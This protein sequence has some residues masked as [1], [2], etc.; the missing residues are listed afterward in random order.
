MKNHK[1]LLKLFTIILLNLSLIASYG[2]YC[3]AC[4]TGYVTCG[5]LI[6]NNS[7]E[8][9]GDPT[10]L[11]Y[12]DGNIENSCCWTDLLTHKSNVD[13]LFVSYPDANAINNYCGG[14][15]WDSSPP[16]AVCINEPPPIYAPFGNIQK[17]YAGFYTYTTTTSLPNWDR[18][19]YFFQ[20]LST[21]IGPG[22]TVNISLQVSL[23]DRSTRATNFHVAF[24]DVL[25]YP[26]NPSD[27]HSHICSVPNSQLALINVVANVPQPSNSTWETITAT[28]TNTSTNQVFDKVIIGNFFDNN[29]T[30]L[31]ANS[32]TVTPTNPHPPS[33]GI[34]EECYYGIDDISIEKTQ[35]CCD[36]RIDH[37]FINFDTGPGDPDGDDILMSTIYPLI[38]PS[39]GSQNIYIQGELIIDG[40]YS[41]FKKNITFGYNSRVTVKQGFTLS[42]AGTPGQITHLHGCDRMW[43]G[44]FADEPNSNVV[45]TNTVI[46]DAVIGVYVKNTSNLTAI[47]SKFIN[48]Y[49]GIQYD[50]YTSPNANQIRGCDFQTNF[51]NTLHHYSIPGN[52]GY[53]LPGYSFEG[54]RGQVGILMNYSD[55]SIQPSGNP[56]QNKFKSL[57]NGVQAY[58]SKLR[59][60]N[61][62]FLQMRN[63]DGSGGVLTDGKA[64]HSINTD[65]GTTYSLQVDNFSGVVK[66][67]Q[68]YNGIWVDGTHVTN[69]NNVQIYN[70]TYRGI[71]HNG[72]LPITTATQITVTNNDI[73]NTFEGIFYQ[74]CGI[75][76]SLT[77]NNYVHNNWVIKNSRGIIVEDKSIGITKLCESSATLLPV[78]ITNN[79][80]NRHGTGI[81]SSNVS[82]L[83][84][85]EN[86]INLLTA[87]HQHHGIWLNRSPHNV[88]TNNSINGNV[89]DWHCIG[90]RVYNSN[91]VH[92]GCNNIDRTEIAFFLDN[93]CDFSRFALNN[94][95]RYNKGF[96]L[97]NSAK[98]GSQ[99]N[100][101]SIDY[102]LQNN[103]DKNPSNQYEFAADPTIVGLN[104]IFFFKPGTGAT[105]DIT[106]I[107]GALLDNSG[108]I[109]LSSNTSVSNFNGGFS[110]SLLNYLRLYDVATATAGLGFNS[111][112]NAPGTSPPPSQ[113]IEG[114]I[115]GYIAN[116]QFSPIYE[117]EHKWMFKHNALRDY[118]TIK[119]SIN[120]S[121]LPPQVILFIDSLYNSNIYE[122]DS[123][124]TLIGFENYSNAYSINSLC[125][126]NCNYSNKLK[127]INHLLIPQW[128]SLAA[129]FQYFISDTTLIQTVIEI[130]NLCIN[131]Y[132]DAVLKARIF[133]RNHID[134]L[135]HIYNPCEELAGLEQRAL[136]SP[137]SDI[138][139]DVLDF[140]LYPNPTSDWITLVANNENMIQWYITDVQ[141]RPI[142]NGNFTTTQNFDMTQW[143]AGMYFMVLFDSVLKENKTIPF[144]I[145]H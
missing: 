96:T 28:F 144:I 6:H 9:T 127:E 98:L 13:H 109:I 107:N 65:G 123:V 48:D 115:N 54:K 132:G 140:N 27:P 36:S 11:S 99:L 35:A 4:E 58:N 116:V 139:S 57:E 135:M 138:V 15:N 3:T 59:F 14:F 97:L 44:V 72:V 100:V 92:V 34:I 90:I 113:I 55:V 43:Q 95:T 73:R 66:T 126:A 24:V 86:E 74:Y 143:K 83:N 60:S 105:T 22:E 103:F 91:D 33:D 85:D 32:Y 67:N 52:I 71:T 7:F 111:C 79:V 46:E 8:S 93:D 101:S 1:F 112:G 2:Q 64:V 51:L 61:A 75:T 17:S 29:N 136:S 89:Q 78:Q 124:E 25:P 125:N 137:N 37:M 88:V 108:N 119:D 133:V 120:P 70:T 102:N 12:C 84:V 40:N 62:D 53:L 19:E 81:H 38:N 49:V 56:Y 130:A 117:S 45:M 104:S 94:I 42:M 31:A 5:E 134:P 128:D 69:I 63:F 26:C 16:I 122:F 30:L 82:C 20:E 129:N 121:S 47:K 87:Q 23:G 76:K 10:G 110:P 21:P 141:G 114:F 145:A 50:H 39:M 68:C 80:I 106:N 41:L 131:E 77:N 18:R 118:K 142:S